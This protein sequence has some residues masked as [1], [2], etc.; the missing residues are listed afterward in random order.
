[1]YSRCSY[2]TIGYDYQ[3]VSPR[4]PAMLALLQNLKPRIVFSPS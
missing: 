2:A 4:A 3:Q 1:M